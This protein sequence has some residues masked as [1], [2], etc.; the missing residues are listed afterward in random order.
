MHLNVFQDA[1]LLFGKLYM[2][3]MH[4][5]MTLMNQGD[6]NTGLYFVVMGQLVVLQHT[7]GTDGTEVSMPQL[8]VCNTGLS[9]MK[10]LPTNK[11]VTS[12]EKIR[13]ADIYEKFPIKPILDAIREGKFR[14]LEHIMR[15]EP[16]S[17]FHEVVNYK[18]KG[19]RPGTTWLKSIGNQ[20]KEKGSSVE[21]VMSQNLYQ[22]RRAWR[23]LFVN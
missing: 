14:W 20:V 19:T 2:R 1:S 15:R 11:S 16:P 23:T 12:R 21:E 22:D 5:G 7:V 13:N 8:H 4:A 3:H 17:M 10:V 6:Q 9:C 18:V